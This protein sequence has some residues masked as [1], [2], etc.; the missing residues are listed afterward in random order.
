M[1]A[2]IRSAASSIL[3]PLIRPSPRGAGGSLRRFATSLQTLPS[4]S[5]YL[6]SYPDRSPSPIAT[7]SAWTLDHPLW[8]TPPISA[9]RQNIIAALIFASDEDLVSALV[10]FPRSLHARLEEHGE[11]WAAS[12]DSGMAF[13]ALRS[14]PTY[15]LFL[16]NLRPS[17]SKVFNRLV[18]TD[19]HHLLVSDILLRHPD[20]HLLRDLLEA[21]NGISERRQIRQTLQLTIFSR[22]GPSLAH[23]LPLPR[24]AV[25]R[26]AKAVLNH[27]SA[28]VETITAVFNQ[29]RLSTSPD[30][31]EEMWTLF[32]LI[33]HAF[34][35]DRHAALQMLSDLTTDS[36]FY[37]IELQSD[38]KHSA[39]ASIELHGTALRF[40]L[41]HKLKLRAQASTEA[42]VASTEHTELSLEGWNCVMESV[43]TALAP[44]DMADASWAARML[45][46][47]SQQRD[48]PPIPSATIESAL[49]GMLLKDRA[50]WYAGLADGSYEPPSAAFLLH[51]TTTRPAPRLWKKII[52]DLMWLAPEETAYVQADILCAL[53]E[54]RM[55]KS[56]H[57]LFSHWGSSQL[58]LEDLCKVIKT[59][60]TD[61]RKSHFALTVLTAWETARPELAPEHRFKLAEMFLT[62]GDP[63]SARRQLASVDLANPEVAALARD[64][65]SNDA[66]TDEGRQMLVQLG[67]V[68]CV[69]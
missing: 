64:F 42:L 16:Q 60:T 57:Q 29:L 13:L 21:N 12:I 46:R 69:A 2:S 18:Q 14:R 19:N 62:L 39:Y 4:P 66:V 48:W 22:I 53:L 37:A 28:S 59:A 54:A 34:R 63:A 35:K 49:E 65:A 1:T 20:P 45:T 43:R 50:G 31:A 27:R 17:L 58:A 51:L 41:M 5:P 40:A 7:S 6:P 55:T 52:A 9:K 10:A 56:A 68:S 47:L 67:V 25:F 30:R 33:H 11:E 23:L 3:P 15:D 44:K 61:R 8:A 32:S 26:L 24:T 38:P 36:P